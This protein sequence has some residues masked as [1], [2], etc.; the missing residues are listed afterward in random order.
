MNVFFQ[1]V[2]A[3]PTATL[4]AAEERKEKVPSP[5]LSHLVVLTSG[6]TLYG[7]AERVVAIESLVFLVEQFEFLQ[8]HLDAVMPAVKK[9]KALSSA[10]LFSV[11]M[12]SE[13]C[14]PIYWI[15]ASKTL[16]MNRCC[17]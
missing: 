13:L 12:A 2:S 6:D 9:K 14:K 8:P 17:I 3:D 10:V 11:S 7:L 16:I 1:E 15:V 4:T 5:H